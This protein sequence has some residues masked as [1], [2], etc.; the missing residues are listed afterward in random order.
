MNAGRFI[1]KQRGISTSSKGKLMETIKQNPAVV[2]QALASLK[3]HDLKALKWV[4][5]KVLAS[6]SAS[7]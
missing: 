1:A 2:L 5:R 4:S 6:M 7:C 3:Q